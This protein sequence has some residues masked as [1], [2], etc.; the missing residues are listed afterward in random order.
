MRVEYLLGTSTGSVSLGPSALTIGAFDGVH[1]G[2]LRL[3]ERTAELARRQGARAVAVTFW[4]HP[5][6]VVRPEP[7][8]ELLAMLDE[9][10]DLFARTEL[11]DTVV[12]VPFTQTLADADPEAFLDMLATFCEPRVLVEGADFAL[13]KGRAGDIAF[14]QTAGERR[15]FAVETLEVRHDDERVS[16]TR[17]RSLVRAGN[18]NEVTTLLGHPYIV[19]GEVVNGDHRGRLLGFPTANLRIDAR[20]VLPGNGVY[21]VRVRLPGEHQASHPA[22]VNIGVRPTFGGEPRLLVEVHLLDATLDLYGQR[23]DVEFVR[24]LRDERRFNG[25]AELIAQIATDAQQ[26]RDILAAHPGRGVV[27]DSRDMSRGD[28]S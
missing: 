26:A 6:E 17:I 24:R 13:G 9:R 19:Y 11:L 2:H 14:L 7:P 21:A 22:V 20:K 3:I 18:I 12:V 28:V 27:T 4:P 15:G 5:L 1:L 23:L 8:V 10:L 25:V 16:S